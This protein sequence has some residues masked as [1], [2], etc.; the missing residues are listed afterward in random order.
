M[1]ADARSLRASQ[2]VDNCPEQADPVCGLDGITYYNECLAL[3]QQVTVQHAGYCKGK[4]LRHSRSGPACGLTTASA[5]HAA[6][7]ADKP[8]GPLDLLS[9]SDQP[10]S[11][12]TCMPR[13]ITCHFY[14]VMSQLSMLSAAF[15]V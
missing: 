5:V 7:F 13:M 9:G 10:I 4:G 3:L 8:L 6:T 11:C 1:L 12:S 2:R 15:M 14:G